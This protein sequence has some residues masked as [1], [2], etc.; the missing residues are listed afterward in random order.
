MAAPDPAWLLL[1]SLRTLEL[2]MERHTA[3]ATEL[4]R[5]LEGHAAVERVR[6]PGFGGLMSFDVAGGADA[7]RAVETGVRLIENATSLGGARTTLETRT[8]WEGDRVPPG[9]VRLSV[10][11]EDVDALCRAKHI[12][13]ENPAPTDEELRM[14]LDVHLCRCTGYQRILEAVQLV[15]A[16][17]RGESLPP[18]DTSGRVGTNLDR[19]EAVELALGMRPYVDDMF[20]PGMLSGAV[21][22]SDHARARVVR[23]DTSKAE[24]M[25]GVRAVATY[26]DVPGERRYGLIIPDW[27][28][29]IAEGELTHCTGS[30]IAAVAADDVRLA[31]AA[32]AAIEVEYEVLEPVVDPKR[33]L[34][35][36]SPK[37]HPTGNKLS[38][39]K[40][41]RGDATAALA[42][43]AH[44]VKQTFKTQRIEHGYLEP[45]SALCVPG[46]DGSFTLYSAGAGHLRRPAAGRA[47]SWACPKSSCT[48]SWCR[49]AAPS[50]AKRTCRSRR[51]PRCSAEMTRRPVKLHAD[52]RGV[53]PTCTPSATRSRWT[54]R[55]A[56]TREGGSP[57]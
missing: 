14:K 42:S 31:R 46:A 45:E 21:R 13:D 50:A 51:R 52:P 54:T 34:L 29:F 4:A 25:P 6:Y 49:T 57:R 24:K 2:R 26:Q 16:V 55:S 15:A 5:R 56:A 12:L 8:R 28:G 40:I 9:L 10:G 41:K 30:F 11:L 39:S 7:A 23:I 43:S 1:R 17:K 32:A 48:S 36:D 53:D 3:S 18:I 20:P 38:H 33:A 22:L 27:P 37:V 47:R 44:V 35:P 19:Y